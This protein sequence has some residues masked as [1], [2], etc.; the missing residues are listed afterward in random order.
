MS[1]TTAA[2]ATVLLLACH[3]GAK[4][5]AAC[6]IVGQRFV[7]LAH[8]Q[9]DDASKAGSVD[10]HT[11]ASVDSHVPA[12]RDSIVRAC[13]EGNWA[14]DLRTCFSTASDGAAMESCY[15]TMPPEQRALLDKAS[16][17]EE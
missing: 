6:E 14:A 4:D 8:R 2:L 7:D 11:R 1:R 12:M 3:R 10:D 13:K 17:P 5:P 9:L 15:Q 16:G